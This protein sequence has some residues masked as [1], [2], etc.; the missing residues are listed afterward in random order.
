[1]K[2]NQ[3]ALEQQCRQAVTALVAR[4]HWSLL[5]EDEFVRRT[6]ALVQAGE[7]QEAQ[8]AAVAV[9]SLALYAACSGQEGLERRSQGYAELWRYLYLHARSRYQDNAEDVVQGAVEQVYRT[10]DRCRHPI[11]FLAFALQSLMNSAR[12]LRQQMSQSCESL[13]AA[14]GGDALRLERGASPDLP[15]V[16]TQLIHQEQRYDLLA[17][18]AAFR[19]AH[20]RAHLQ[21]TALWLKYVDGLDDVEIGQR[22]GISVENVYVLRARARKKLR[23]DPLWQQLAQSYG[24]EIG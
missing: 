5:A 13:D 18:L 1:M 15:D 20:P 24:Y 21:L 23:A 10:F 8:R 19:R 3:P 7:A 4:H 6:L 12:T 9:Y 11:A 2:A 14:Q 22:L 16:A 17:C